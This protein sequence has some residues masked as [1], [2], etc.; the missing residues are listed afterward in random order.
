MAR[1]RLRPAQSAAVEQKRIQ[2]GKLPS[3]Q[4]IMYHLMLLTENWAENIKF[5]L[6]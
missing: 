5:S 1:E 3:K 6:L 2:P 4:F